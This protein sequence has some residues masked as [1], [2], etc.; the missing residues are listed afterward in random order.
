MKNFIS[1]FLGSSVRAFGFLPSKQRVAVFRSLEPHF[2]S[3]VKKRSKT[4]LN[5]QNVYPSK[6]CRWTVRRKFFGKKSF[7]LSINSHAV[8]RDSWISVSLSYFLKTSSDHKNLNVF[9]KPKRI[10]KWF[11]HYNNNLWFIYLTLNLPIALGLGMRY[12]D[13]D[14]RNLYDELFIFKIK[15]FTKK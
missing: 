1:I 9:K 14:F 7:L 13:F 10:L 3:A 12:S 8:G 11:L 15:K 4:C 6:F 5:I 2:N